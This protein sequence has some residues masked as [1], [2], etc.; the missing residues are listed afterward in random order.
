MTDRVS[1]KPWEV[2]DTDTIL[3]ADGEVVCTFYST[4]RGHRRRVHAK[5][6]AEHIVA[7]VNRTA[8]AEVKK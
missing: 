1:P 7:C 4:G 2:W 8:E 6:N 5:N 3:D